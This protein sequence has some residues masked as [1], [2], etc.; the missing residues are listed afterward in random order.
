MKEFQQFNGI[1]GIV[2]Y[3]LV[4]LVVVVF[5]AVF[6]DE[7]EDPAVARALRDAQSLSLQLAYGGLGELNSVANLGSQRLPASVQ[8]G[9]K[10]ELSQKEFGKQGRI[11]TDPWGNQFRYQFFDPVDGKTQRLAVWSYGP[12]T[13]ADTTFSFSSLGAKNDPGYIQFNGDD[14]G[15]VFE[16]KK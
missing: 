2:W 14:V 8:K 11:G 9:N 16:I 4:A 10:S 13:K 1:D 6:I 5:A 7:K 3:V 12:N 15:Y